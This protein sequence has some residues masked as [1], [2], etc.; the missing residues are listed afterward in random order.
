MQVAI[1]AISPFSACPATDGNYQQ[2]QAIIPGVLSFHFNGRVDL[3]T[4]LRRTY[5]YLE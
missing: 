1:A 2:I 3:P 5:V 4:F